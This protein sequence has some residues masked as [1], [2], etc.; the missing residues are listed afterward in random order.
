MW[1][2]IIYSIVCAAQ[3]GLVW[4]L[5]IRLVRSYLV[6]IFLVGVSTDARNFDSRYRLE[7]WTLGSLV[8]KTYA[9]Q[10]D[11]NITGITDNLNSANN[12]TFDYD[13]IHRL[14]TANGPWGAGSYSYDANGNRLTKVEGASSTSYT[15][16]AGTNRLA[17]ATG[18]EPATY[19]YDANRNT[20][21]D[22]THTYW[23]WPPISQKAAAGLAV[24][25]AIGGLRHCCNCPLC[26]RASQILEKATIVWDESVTS[27]GEVT[28]YDYFTGTVRLAPSAFNADFRAWTSKCTFTRMG[29]ESALRWKNLTASAMPFSTRHRLA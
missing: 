17:T 13:A 15:Y 20:T 6:R 16:T 25:N 28:A 18:S 1:L 21:S 12:R 4:F 29:E 11:D 2:W 26:L 22:G 24:V 19:G 5:S 7:T 27:C 23:L 8:S 9:W 10:D 14:T 3:A